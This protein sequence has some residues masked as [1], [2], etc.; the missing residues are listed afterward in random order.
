MPS[1]KIILERICA[2]TNT[3]DHD[4]PKP[5]NLIVPNE[6]VSSLLPTTDIL[7]IYFALF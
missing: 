6:H 3:S 4:Q 5:Y 2:E 1:M 7:L